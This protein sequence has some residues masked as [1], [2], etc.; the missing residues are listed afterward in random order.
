MIRCLKKRGVWTFMKVKNP[1]K[2]ELEQLVELEQTTF[3]S[4][5]AASR[6]SVERR[7]YAH[8][9]TFWVLKKAGRIIAGINGIT[10]NEHDLRDE[11]Y[12]GE[13]FY[14]KN[15]RWLMIFSV[16]T[17]PEYQHNGYAAKVMKE[18]IQETA[19]CK[20]DGIVLTCKPEMISF[21]EQFG[22]VDEGKSSSKHGGAVW[23]QMRLERSAIKRDYRGEILDCL[24]TVAIAVVIAFIF[25]HFIILNCNV[26]T[27]SMLE[28]IQLDDNIIGNRITYK[29]SDPKRGDIAIF[30]WPDD[31]TQVYIKRIIGL[32][33]ETVEIK[34]GKV[35]INGSDTPL[36]EDYLSDE[37]RT[38]MRSFGPY[39]VPED[40]YFMLGDNRPNSADARLWDNTYVKREKIL[41]KAE[42]V[43]YPFSE[44]KWLGN[45]AEY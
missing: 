41:A 43:Y 15:G 14:D 35:Y 19:R 33:G 22:F 45:G 9:E 21:Y 1:K 27:G 37:A 44:I 34:E 16:S 7:L 26:P 31:E 42:F 3:P 17:L 32:P 18:V 5:E 2:R 13:E 24:V 23:H 12:A 11:M 28:T 40:S 4:A 30:K 25:G 6:E 38:D 29:F 36:N 39:Q 20:L 8:R 10:T